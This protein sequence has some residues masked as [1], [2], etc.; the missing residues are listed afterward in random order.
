MWL[1][2]KK[3]SENVNV[4][5]EKRIKQLENDVLSLTT[6]ME[7][8]RNNVLRKLQTRKQKIEE[9]PETKPG[10]GIL[11]PEQAKVYQNGV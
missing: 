3:T 8:M 4:S 10:G 7:I 2:G 5:Y 11:T 1:F 9:Q 6:D